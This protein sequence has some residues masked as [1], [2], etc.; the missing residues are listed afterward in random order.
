MN[1]IDSSPGT[2]L[3]ISMAQ[4]IAAADSTTAAAPAAENIIDEPS[5]VWFLMGTA[6]STMLAVGF[7]FFNAA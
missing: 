2:S 5:I 7:I 1:A 4:N 6:L 3:E